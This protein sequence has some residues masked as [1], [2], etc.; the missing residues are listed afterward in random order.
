M[1]HKYFKSLNKD[2]E[3]KVCANC[4]KP[5]KSVCGNCKFERYCSR[6]CQKERWN[7]HSMLC[8][9]MRDVKKIEK[10]ELLT[11]KNSKAILWLKEIGENTEEIS[12]CVL[13]GIEKGK[14]FW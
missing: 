3:K 11:K 13:K 5:S 2:Y 8:N 7:I 10:Q 9:R 14:Y 1:N 12:R 6:E 4:E